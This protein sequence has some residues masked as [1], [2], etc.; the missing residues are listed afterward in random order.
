LDDANSIPLKRPVSLFHFGAVFLIQ[1]TPI[2]AR[3]T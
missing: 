2:S 3:L 1:K